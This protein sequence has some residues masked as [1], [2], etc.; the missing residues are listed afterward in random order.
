MKNSNLTY[1]DILDRLGYFMNK[2]SITAYELSLRLGHCDNYI[3]RIQVGRNKLSAKTLIDCLEIL[4][5]ST[6]QFFY[7]DLENYD[8][9][10][11]KLKTINSLTDEEFQSIMTILN[12]KKK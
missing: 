11:E 2:K 12:I 5:V 6:S 3:Y 4:E 7:P 8:K 1:K 9:D 10:M